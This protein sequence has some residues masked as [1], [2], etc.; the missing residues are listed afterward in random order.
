[1]DD[2]KIFLMFLGRR[3]YYLNRPYYY[4]RSFGMNTI[5]GMV[6]A[7]AD[8]QDFQAYLQSLDCTH[9][10]MQTNLVDKYLHDNFSEKTII[11]FL[12]LVKEY[13]KQIYKSNGYAVMEK[14]QV[15]H[16]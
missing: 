4:E 8:K 1:P 3:G 6:K 5:N 10:L 13:W 12:D 14:T 11:R 9:I 7:S 15:S 16:P 2:V